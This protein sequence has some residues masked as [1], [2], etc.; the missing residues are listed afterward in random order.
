ML[1]EFFYGMICGTLMAF[2]FKNMVIGS[3]MMQLVILMLRL[4]LSEE[5]NSGCGMQPNLTSLLTSKASLA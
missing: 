3:S 4:I 1:P 5:I 2:F